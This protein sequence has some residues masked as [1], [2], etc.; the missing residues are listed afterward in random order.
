M[1]LILTAIRAHFS[2]HWSSQ[3]NFWSGV[4]GMMINNSLTLLGIWAMLFAGKTQ[5]NEARNVF[6]LMNFI[7]M[8]AWGFV[9]GILGG[10]AS[11]DKQINEG[12][13]DLAMTTPR[14]PFLMLSI[15]RSD[16]PSWGDLALGLSGLLGFGMVFGVSYFFRGL[17]MIAFSTLVVYSFFLC[18]GCLAFWFRR[19]EAA[20][21]VLVNM[22]LAFNTYPIFSDATVF[23][24][25]I[26]VTPALLAGLIPAKYVLQPTFS[27]LALEAVGSLL[28]FLFARLVFALGLRR[29]QSAAGLGLQRG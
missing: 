7:L 20:Y 22:F 10:V 23:R 25:A 2:Q 11:L 18:V 6:F 27:A 4:I 26:F 12:G 24:W 13:L 15:T 5:F 14:S 19:T 1:R 16:L 21:S 9:H 28:I 29:Y 3:S 17:L 8:T